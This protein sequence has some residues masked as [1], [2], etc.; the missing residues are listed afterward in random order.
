MSLERKEER[1]KKTSI[2][3]HSQSLRAGH[4]SLGR[5]PASVYVCVLDVAVAKAVW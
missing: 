2:P 5:R 4:A 1:M 3:S